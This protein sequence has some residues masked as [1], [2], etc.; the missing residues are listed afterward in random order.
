MDETAIESVA[1]SGSIGSDALSIWGL[2]LNADA[3]VKAVILILVVASFW[4]WTII[5][6]KS[7]I[8]PISKI[9]SI[10]VCRVSLGIRCKKTFLEIFLSCPQIQMQIGGKKTNS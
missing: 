5:F 9:G 7:V 6:E 10:R 3:V 2:L 8:L 1:L 4:C